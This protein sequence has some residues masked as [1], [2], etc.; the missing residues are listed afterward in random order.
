MKLATVLTATAATALLSTAA[1]AGDM[2]KAKTMDSASSM[3][4]Q[5]RTTTMV[6][7]IDADGQV[8]TMQ[9]MANTPRE[10][11]V[12]G[13]LATQRTDAYVVEDSQGDLHLNHLVDVSELPEYRL[14]PQVID[15]VTFEHNGMT[16]TNRV[17]RDQTFAAAQ[18]GS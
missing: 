13:A 12:L 2:H 1:H 16:F 14:D 18:I 10:T 17:V 8:G 11:A 6:K 9:V 3:P 5:S 15:T 7:T 4:V